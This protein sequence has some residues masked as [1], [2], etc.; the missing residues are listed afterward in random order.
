MKSYLPILIFCVGSTALAAGAQTKTMVVTTVSSESM[1]I[2][3]STETHISFSDDLSEMIVYSGNPD[4]P[5]AFDIDD[6]VNIVFTMTSS[7]DRISAELDDLLISN[8][9]GMV[10]ISGAGPIEYSAWDIAGSFVAS[11]RGEQVVTLDF[12]DRP[13]GVYILRVNNKTLKFINR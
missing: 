6:I 12:T 9:G 5:L 1:P 8:R 7:S 4:N 3:V 13:A 2:P 11:G 10:T